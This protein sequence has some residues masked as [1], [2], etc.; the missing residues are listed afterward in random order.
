MA[1]A[2]HTAL[3]ATARALDDHPAVLEARF[4]LFDGASLDVFSRTLERLARPRL[5][6]HS[7]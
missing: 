6:P 7:A 4:W 2:A 3:A 1:D 5:D